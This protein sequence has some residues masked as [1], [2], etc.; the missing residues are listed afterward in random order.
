M[1]RCDENVY[2]SINQDFHRSGKENE[3]CEV[4]TQEAR[5][6]GSL[7][8]GLRCDS[9]AVD[10]DRHAAKLGITYPN[11]QPSELHG[12]AVSPYLILCFQV[13]PSFYIMGSIFIFLYRTFDPGNQTTPAPTV[14]VP[15]RPSPGSRTSAGLPAQQA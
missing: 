15:T 2:G 7:P 5:V 13:N 14:S 3:V 11:G 12:M 6:D 1:Y 9:L 4:E 8:I 10:V